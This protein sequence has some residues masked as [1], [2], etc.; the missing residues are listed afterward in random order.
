MKSHKQEFKNLNIRREGQLLSLKNFSW[1]EEIK[2]FPYGIP[3]L[4]QSVE[5]G[6]IAEKIGL[7]PR[8]QILMID[9]IPVNN[10]QDLVDNIQSHWLK[11]YDLSI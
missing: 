11:S 5:S 4:I 1:D 10:I 2:I 9:Q 8:D 3:I 6:S 7:K